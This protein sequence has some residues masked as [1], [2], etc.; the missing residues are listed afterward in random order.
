MSL[1]LLR[2]SEVM[3]ISSFLLIHVRADKWSTDE[4]KNWILESFNCLCRDLTSQSLTFLFD[5]YLCVIFIIVSYRYHRII[6]EAKVLVLK[7][8]DYPKSVVTT[9]YSY[10]DFG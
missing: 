3:Y 1:Q 10:Y 4:P 8:I 2:A 9:V 5:R 7:Q 6:Y